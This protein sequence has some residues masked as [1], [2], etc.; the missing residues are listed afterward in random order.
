MGFRELNVELT[1]KHAALWDATKVSD[2]SLAPCSIELDKLADPQDVIVK[3]FHLLGRDGKTYRDGL[4]ADGFSGGIRRAGHG[5][6]ERC[7]GVRADGLGG[8]G[9]GGQ[10]GVPH[11]PFSWAQMSP[12]PEMLELIR[13]FCA[14]TDVKLT[15]CWALTERTMARTGFS[16]KIKIRLF[17]DQVR[18][19]L[20]GNEYVLEG[21]KAA[22]QQRRSPAIPPCGLPWIRQRGCR[23]AV[24][25]DPP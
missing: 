18:A 5:W 8:I 16:S 10:L 21:Q 2:S 17:M 23:E 14:D 4:H 19:R 9:S 6:L 22:W 1:K 7:S 3:G 15:G 11:V 24:C 25:A 13:R 12:D 20:D